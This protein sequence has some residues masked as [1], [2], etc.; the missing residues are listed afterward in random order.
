MRISVSAILALIIWF[1]VITQ[2]VLMLQN[3]ATLAAETIIRFF[4]FF[5]ILTNTVVATYFTAQSFRIST[6]NK[7]GLLT[8]ITVYIFIVGIVYQL[9]LRHLWQ[10]A[11][12][13]WVV[14]ELLHTINPLLVII[15]WYAYERKAE[16]NY[17][18]IK[19][20]LIYPI[21]YLLYILIRGSVSGFYPYPFVNV[22]HI[23]LAKTLVNSALLLLLFVFVSFI[24]IAIGRKT[25]RRNLLPV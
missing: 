3:G 4:S 5:T 24:F 2:L 20:W 10:P 8:A 12:M 14:D 21:I 13:Q 15:Y 7:P 18:Q 6:A 11:G 19:G 1:A 25:A 22:A 23:G 9:L 17:R 16:V